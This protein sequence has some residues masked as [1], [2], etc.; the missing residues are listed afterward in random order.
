MKIQQYGREQHWGYDC[1]KRALD[2][3]LGVIGLLLFAPIFLIAALAVRLDSKGN[4]FFI[5][6]RI[7]LK[8][9]PFK[10]IKLRGMYIDAKQRFPELYDYSGHDGLNFHF[11]YEQDPRV[12]RV[13]RFTR[14]TSIDELPNFI[15]VVLGDMSLVG[16]RPEVPDVMALYGEYAEQYLSVKPGITCLSKCSGRDALTK[17]ET[18]QLDLDYIR[19]RSFLLDMKVLWWTFIGVLLRRDVH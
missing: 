16:P 7:G 17:E 15:N 5:Q 13:G 12:T 6:K 19:R 11:H 10:I 8:G 18:I 1:T 9:K 2:L 3:L 14:R 4:P